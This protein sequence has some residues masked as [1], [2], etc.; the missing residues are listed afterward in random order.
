MKIRL[1][2]GAR[3]TLDLVA[4]IVM[5]SV[6]VVF[7]AAA[8]NGHFRRS[9]ASV[10]IEPPVP[11]E[12]VSL[13]GAMIAG[14]PSAPIVVIEWADFRCAAC[15]VLAQ[16]TLPSIRRRYVESCKVRFAFR[17]LPNS[18][19]DPLAVRAAEVA[20][21]AGRQGQFWP[22]HDVLFREQ[23][24]LQASGLRGLGKRFGIDTVEF[25]ACL[26]HGSTLPQIRLDAGEGLTLGV[27]ATPTLF[28][29]IVQRDARIVKA[30]VE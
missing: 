17:H 19:R 7:I 21:C 22:M 14:C 9:R 4:T 2:G 5:L 1:S 6:A 26:D 15:G 24:Q 20:A 30:Y 29:A 25:G 27:S 10:L 23:S 3:T 28:F 13:K 16:R 12:S 18:A 8:A 11:A